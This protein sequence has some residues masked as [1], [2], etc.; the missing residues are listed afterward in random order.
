MKVS[1]FEKSVTGFSNAFNIVAS[2]SLVGMML[3]TCADV[4]MRYVFSRPIIGTYDLVS[5]MGAVLVSFAMPYTMLKKGHVAV[6]ILIQRLSK[7]TQLIIE[8]F[9][10]LIGISLF[11]VLVWQAILLS[12]DMKAAGEVTPTLLLPF[13]PIVYCM[14]ICFFGL[15][16]AIL[17]NLLEIWTKRAK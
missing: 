1:L 7:G 15:C 6:E 2:A 5:L 14:A 9:T 4:V 12:R 16:L 11:L 3:L 17:V 10:H 13:Y 8:T